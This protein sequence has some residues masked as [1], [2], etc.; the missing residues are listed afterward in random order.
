MRGLRRAGG[1]RS[2]SRNGR[3]GRD[4]RSC[5]RSVSATASL[6]PDRAATP[7]SRPCGCR[8]DGGLVRGLRLDAGAGPF[9]RYASPV[10]AATE[11]ATRCLACWPR[12]SR[13][14]IS[15]ITVLELR[16]RATVP[17]GCVPGRAGQPVR[18]RRSGRSVASGTTVQLRNAASRRSACSA[19]ASVVLRSPP[20]ARA[21]RRSRGVRHP[22]AAIASSAFGVCGE[23]RPGRTSPAQVGSIFVVGRSFR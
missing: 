6:P 23:C 22:T 16:S 10:S 14:W 21:P 5:C 15:A 12:P 20:G 4:P 3:C 18:G 11:G 19:K 1:H 7:T 2:E 8:G 17:A 13:S 9:A